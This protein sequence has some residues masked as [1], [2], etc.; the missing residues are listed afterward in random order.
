MTPADDDV[1][2]MKEMLRAAAVD[3][4]TGFDLCSQNRLRTQ[5]Q[6]THDVRQRTVGHLSKVLSQFQRLVPEEHHRVS[7]ADMDAW[8]RMVC[9]CLPCFKGYRER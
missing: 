1:L 7:N 8:R 6:Q 9:V 2:H 4:L 3:V 5:R